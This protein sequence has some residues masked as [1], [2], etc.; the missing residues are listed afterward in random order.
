MDTLHER[1]HKRVSMSVAAA[2]AFYF[3]VMKTLV[4]TAAMESGGSLCGQHTL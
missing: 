3:G 2:M 4:L 1:F